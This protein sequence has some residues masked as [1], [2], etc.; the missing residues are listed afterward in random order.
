VAKMV[1]SGIL[2]KLIETLAPSLKD[3]NAWVKQLKKENPNLTND[4]LDL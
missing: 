3:V 1:D 2:I 4:E